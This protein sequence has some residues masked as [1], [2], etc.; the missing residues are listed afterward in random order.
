MASL[1]TAWYEKVAGLGEPVGAMG[2]LQATGAEVSE[3]DRSERTIIGGLECVSPEAFAAS[4]CYT[5]L[6]HLHRAQR[7]SG[8][9]N[10]RYAGAPIPMSFAEKNNRHGVVCVTVDG[11][12]TAIELRAFEPPVS[13]VAVGGAADEREA[14]SG[15]VPAGGAGAPGP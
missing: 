15:R 11:P 13:L 6:G 14:S 10:V 12:S 7:V 8:R 5:A 2:Q 3:N 9:D 1:Y 4:I